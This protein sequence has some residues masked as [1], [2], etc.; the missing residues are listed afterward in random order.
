MISGLASITFI[1]LLAMAM[2]HMMWAFGATYPAKTEADLARTVIGAQGIEKMQSRGLSFFLSLAIFFA[3]IWAL[4]LT[5]PSDTLVLTLGGV[6]FA[7]VFL[8]RGI[9]GYTKSWRARNPEEPFASFNIRLYSPLC[10]LVG[11]G[12]AW[13]TL[14]RII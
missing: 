5:D 9:L 6:F 1:P 10:L 3:G 12:F 7:M 13:L 14:L 11:I 2:V 8:A 4:A